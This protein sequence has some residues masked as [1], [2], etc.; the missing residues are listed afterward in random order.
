ME[1]QFNFTLYVTATVVLLL[2]AIVAF[3][4]NSLVLVAFKC[5][6]HIRKPTTCLICGLSIAD[7]G[8]VIASPLGECLRQSRGTHIWIYL[9]HI[10]L[11]IF[12]LTSVGN[13]TFSALIALERLFT[14]SF[15]MSY[16]TYITTERTATCVIVTW[17]YLVTTVTVISIMSHS[18]LANL[19]QIL[20]NE[21][22]LVGP[23]A[24]YS[25]LVT[26]F[27]FLLAVTVTSYLLIARI[28][29]QQK[30][31]ERLQV[32]FSS[33]WR[34]TKMVGIVGL[35][36]VL[37]YAPST[38]TNNLL[39]RGILTSDQHVV[40]YMYTQCIFFVSAMINPFLYA[41]KT[42]YF[43]IAFRKLLPTWF[44]RHTLLNNSVDVI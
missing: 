20:L 17:V 36:F 21:N 23:N 9:A 2:E 31:K 1:A 42:S 13:V 29:V 38:I 34:I 18:Y 30:R 27:Y 25:F 19:P 5:Y 6:P 12:I 11:V 24:P 32:N 8:G 7:M 26:H 4:A 14:L 37:C 43:R 40:Y 39:R 22:I 33:Q 28:A 35:V 41:A 10:R 15:P 16:M 3:A 44:V